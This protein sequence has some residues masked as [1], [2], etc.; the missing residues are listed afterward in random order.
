MALIHQGNTGPR[1]SAT[2]R[3]PPTGPAKMLSR[4][5][6]S[7]RN[8]S[9]RAGVDPD[10]TTAA[11]RQGDLQV[12]G[13]WLPVFGT[14]GPRRTLRR[15]CGRGCAGVTVADALEAA[16]GGAG[17]GGAVGEPVEGAAG[18]AAQH[19][20][21]AGREPARRGSAR[22]GSLSADAPKAPAR[23]VDGQSFPI[24]PGS[25]RAS[26]RATAGAGSCPRSR[27]RALSSPRSEGNS[28]RNGSGFSPLRAPRSAARRQGG[29]RAVEPGRASR[30][31]RSRGRSRPSPAEDPRRSRRCAPRRWHWQR[32]AA[33]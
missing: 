24:P 21:D 31:R 15:A 7:C 25:A 2:E 16:A 8:S 13:G 4:R 27:S 14:P 30:S 5:A 19:R 32:R 22:R 26:R 33:G 18:V 6:K 11:V 28:R 1:S 9:L 17:Q 12:P 3:W 29:R 10:T 20:R 23:D